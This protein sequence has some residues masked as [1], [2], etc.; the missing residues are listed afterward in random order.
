M[1]SFEIEI[2]IEEKTGDPISKE[3]LVE[4]SASRSKAWRVPL[5]EKITIILY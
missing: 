2:E 5:T 3:N 1:F 4:Q